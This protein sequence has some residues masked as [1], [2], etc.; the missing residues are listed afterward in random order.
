[1][2]A[3]WNGRGSGICGQKG[4]ELHLLVRDIALRRR[5]TELALGQRCGLTVRHPIIFPC[6]DRLLVH[7]PNT[8]HLTYASGLK[9]APVISGN[10]PREACLKGSSSSNSS[11]SNSSSGSKSTAQ[12]LCLTTQRAAPD[13]VHN[14]NNSKAEGLDPPVWTFLKHMLAWAHWLAASH[15]LRRADAA[16]AGPTAIVVAAPPAYNIMSPKGSSP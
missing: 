4:G 9:L 7:G 6:V 13:L 5:G 2:R 8:C 12:D 1:M 11:S 10:S 16:A 15:V 3:V 14:G